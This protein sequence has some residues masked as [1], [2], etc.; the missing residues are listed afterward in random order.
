LRK[1]PGKCYIWNMV[2]YGSENLT[3]QAADLE[4]FYQHAG[5]NLR[6]KPGKCYIWNMVLYGSENLTLQAADLEILGKF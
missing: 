2:L 6:K 5:L 4:S 3:L 1:K